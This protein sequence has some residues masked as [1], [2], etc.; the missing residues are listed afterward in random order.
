EIINGFLNEPHQERIIFTLNAASLLVPSYNFPEKPLSKMVYF[1]R[2]EI[3]STLTI[4]NM[5]ESL[6]IGDLLPNVLENLSVICDDVIFPLLN[7][8]VN[9]TGWTSVIVNDMKTE[10]QNLRNGIAQMKGLV[11]NRTILPLPICIDE[12]MANAPAIAR[13]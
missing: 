5:H 2:N 11:I 12:V 3:P 13:G 1:V 8:P 7:N 4:N 9:Q 6:M 10:S